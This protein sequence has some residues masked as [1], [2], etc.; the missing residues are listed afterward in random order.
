MKYLSLIFIIF[1]LSNCSYQKLNFDDKGLDID[2]YT[3]DMTYEKFM[4][5]VIDYA[6]KASYPSLTN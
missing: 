2:I 6:N 4:K 1:T 3:S 5:I